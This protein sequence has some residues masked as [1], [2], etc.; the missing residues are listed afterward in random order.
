MS[1]KIKN[2]FFSSLPAIILSSLLAVAV[3]YAFTEPTKTP[4]QGNVAAPINVGSSSQIKGGPLQV[5]GFRNIGTTILDGSVGIGT[6]NPQA[7]LDVAGQIKIS[8]GNP[9]EG[10]VL[11]SD[12]SGLASWQPVNV[13][14]TQNV[15]TPF[16]T[17][18]TYL[19][20]YD[21]EFY[22]WVNNNRDT[23]TI[24]NPMPRNG[25]DDHGWYIRKLSDQ[26]FKDT[27]N[28]L[29]EYLTGG[30]ATITK[31]SNTELNVFS[32]NHVSGG[33]YGSDNN[34][35]AYYWDPASSKWKAESHGDN[36]WIDITWLVCEGSPL[37][38]A[39]KFIKFWR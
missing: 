21:N 36:G 16:F 39:V 9:G 24:P 17:R 8:G 25:G 19:M 31:L 13:G 7:K 26:K 15:V 18:Y 34:N 23:I 29:C 11:T 4:P 10:K 33:D 38:R 5:N 14:N 1:Q 28:K 2:I 32:G 35:I 22:N 30:N 37:P 6:M 12:A 20:S 3:I 27:A